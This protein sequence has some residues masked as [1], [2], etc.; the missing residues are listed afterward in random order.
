MLGPGPELS[1][2]DL[3]AYLNEGSRLLDAGNVLQVR[4]RAPLLHTPEHCSE[5]ATHSTTLIE[6]RYTLE[7]RLRRQ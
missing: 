1:R 7:S 5:C 6:A 3:L 2:A 4:T